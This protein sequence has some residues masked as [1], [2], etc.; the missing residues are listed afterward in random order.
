MLSLRVRED[1]AVGTFRLPTGAFADDT[2]AFHFSYTNA[3]GRTVYT[4]PHPLRLT[5]PRNPSR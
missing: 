2:F 4:Q 5:F 3:D 1:E